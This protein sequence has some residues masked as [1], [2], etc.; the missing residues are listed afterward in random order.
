MQTTSEAEKMRILVTGAGGFIGNRLWAFLSQRTDVRCRGMLRAGSAMDS[1]RIFSDAMQA[2]LM[3]AASLA[4]VCTDVDAIIHCAGHAHAFNEREG[5]A[6]RTQMGI[7]FL[8]TRNLLDAAV[9][10]GVRHFVYLSSVKAAGLP[11]AAC[12][13]ECW[14]EEPETVYGQAKKRAEQAVLQISKKHGMKATCLR[15]AM[16]YG[17]GS[18]GNLERMMRGVQGRWFPPLPHN[19]S[20]RSLVHVSD[21][22]DAAWTVLNDPRAAGKVYIIADPQTYSGGE[23][24]DAIRTALGRG[25]PLWR[26]PGH[27]LRRWGRWGD[28]GARILRRPLPLNSEVVERLLGAESYSAAKIESELGWRAQVE[29]VDGLRESLGIAERAR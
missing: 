11:G 6:V 27:W 12:A 26:V 21:V 29:L 1:A 5:D 28:R 13:D 19:Q 17:R 9:K 8:G 2:D 7:N 14:P 4:R 25:Q 16:V 22:V 20:R 23:I 15:L 24:Y 18:K 10:N 3:D